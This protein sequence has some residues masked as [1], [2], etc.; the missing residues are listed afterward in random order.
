MS[1]HTHRPSVANLLKNNPFRRSRETKTDPLEMSIDN[2]SDEENFNRNN[3]TKD[4]SSDLVSKLNR[5]RNIS[6]PVRKDHKESQDSKDYKHR[7]EP[8]EYENRQDHEPSFH[9]ANSR[10]RVFKRYESDDS[11]SDKDEGDENYKDKNHKD[12]IQNNRNKLKDTRDSDSEQSDMDRKDSKHSKHKK[13]NRSQ[14]PS[15]PPHRGRHAQETKILKYSDEESSD[16]EDRS[17]KYSKPQSEE[18]PERS[19]KIHRNKNIPTKAENRHSNNSDDSDTSDKFHKKE[20]RRSRNKVE[21]SFSALPKSSITKMAKLEGV[22]SLSADV[23]DSIKDLAGKFID[24]VLDTVSQEDSSIITSTELEPIVEKY[25]KT[26][27]EDLEQNDINLTTMARFIKTVADKYNIT[28]KK[29]AVF[30]LH[31]STENF[32]R[33]LF[34]NALSIAKNAKRVRVT[35]KDISLSFRM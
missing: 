24:T 35:S 21:T 33:N 30:Y 25:L 2:K 31:N 11:N 7:K 16:L 8:Q 32:I 13:S 1:N 17:E 26:K 27:V 6:S 10:Q 18:I 34:Y 12:K 19:R 5:L 9:R 22:N 15:T 28:I 23:Y 3:D 29:E 4:D 20:I 14:S